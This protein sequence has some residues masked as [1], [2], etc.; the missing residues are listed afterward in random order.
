MLYIKNKNRLKLHNNDKEDKYYILKNKVENC[1]NIKY[2]HTKN[3][4]KLNNTIKKDFLFVLYLLN[5][6]INKFQ[7]YINIKKE[8]IVEIRELNQDRD[9]LHTEEIN[10]IIKYKN[11]PLLYIIININHEFGHR[12]NIN[13]IKI[14]E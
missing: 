4:F 2:N 9:N 7:D 11:L 8:N 5:N 12:K 10:D 1:D 13:I 14:K 3:Q 6:K